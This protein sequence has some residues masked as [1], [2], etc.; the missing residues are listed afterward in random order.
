[1]NNPN[2]IMDYADTSE[3]EFERRHDM[4]ADRIFDFVKHDLEII[5]QAYNDNVEDNLDEVPIKG[6]LQISQGGF[7]SDI[8]DSPTWLELSAVANEQVKTTKNFNNRYL[9]N[10]RVL[11]EKNG[12]K[13]CQFLLDS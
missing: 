2:P 12:I 3:A 7:S 9:K 4:I 11:E 6:K 1:M 10:I 13:I 5:Y 8:L